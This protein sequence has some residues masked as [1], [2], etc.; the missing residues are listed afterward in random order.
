MRKT[1]E[2]STNILARFT[3]AA[4]CAMLLL[5]LG[6]TT[7]SAQL[8]GTKNIPGDYATLAA[9]ITDLNAQGVGAGG[10]TISLAAANPQTAPAGGY[11]IGDTGSF[12]LTTASAANPI[13]IQGNGNTITAPTTQVVGSLNDAIFKL[14]GADFVTISGFTMTENAA[15]TTTAA[16][17]NN[18]TEFGVALFYV[19]A[20]DGA[21][22]NSIISNT[23]DLD[24]TYQN[25][26]G[27]YSN[28]R[29]N[30][31]AISTTADITAATGANNNLTVRSNTIT[32]VNMGVVSIGS[33]TT[34]FYNVG[35]DIGGT[36]IATGN[37]ITNFGTTATFSGYVSV[38]GTVNGAY[39][40]NTVNAN[41]SYNTIN[42]SNGGVTVST[43]LR[44]VFVQNTG[45]APTTGGPFNNTVNNN[46]I[47]LRPANATA[48]ITAIEN[49]LGTAV[50]NF[51][52]NTNDFNTTGHTVAATGAVTFI[53]SSVANQNQN[54]NNNTFSNL[55]LNT[56]GATTFIVASVSLPANG[57]QNVNGNSIVTAFNK[58]GAGGMVT[59]FTNNGSSPGTVVEQNNNNNFSNITVTGAT[60]IV[61]FSNTDGGTPTKTVTGN[62]FNN[63]TGGTSAVTAL[64]V[65]FQ[66]QATVSGNTV[67]NI[68]NG[69]AITGIS[70]AS[71]GSV[72]ADVLTQN[73]VFNLTG[74]GTGTVVGISNSG[75]TT[76]NIT[77]NR[78]YNISN[79]NALPVASGIT[80]S[81]G[82]TINVQNN[83]VGNI[84]TPNSGST[85]SLFGINIS[86]GTTV[87]AD[88]NTVYLN[89]TS[90]GANFGSSALNA[91]TTPNV[92]L[93]NNNL[94]NLSTATGT[95]VTVAY[96]R[97][98]AT[99]TTYNAASNANNLY[100]GTPGIANLLY[101]DSATGDQTLAA[102]KAR[103]T[104]RDGSSVSVNPPFLSTTGSAPTFLHIDP[105]IATQLESG[106]VMVAGITV[107]FDGDTRNNPPDIGADEFAGIGIDLTGPSI[108]YTPLVN[109]ATTTNRTLNVTITDL[110]GVAGGSLSPRIYF[111]KNGGAFFSTQCTG[112]AP[113][114]VCTID[115]ALIGGVVAADIVRYFVIAQDTLNNVSANPGAGLVASDVNNV[116]TP[117]TTP[118]QYTIV[119]AFPASVSVGTAGADY[120]S[121]TNAGGLFAALNAGTLNSNVTVNIITD[122]TGELGTIQLGQLAEDAPGGFIVTIKPTGAARIITGSSAAGLITLNGA[123]R[124]VIDGSTSGGTDR[125]LTINNTN[126]GTSAGVIL[127]SSGAS[128]AQS[129]TVRNVN[130]IGNAAATLTTLSGIHVG[131]AT[132]GSLATVPNTNIVLNNNSIQSTIFGISSLGV[133]AAAKDTGT[134]ITGN[135]MTGTGNN[136][137]GRVGMYI[138]YNN[139][140][141]IS[142][143]TISGIVSAENADAVGIAVGQQG[144]LTI[145]A[146]GAEVSNAT[147]SQNNI[148]IVQQTNTFSA[149]GIILG[150]STTGTNNVV[151][152]TV[153]GVIGNSNSGDIVTGIYVGTAAGGT[154][155]VNFNSVSMTGDRGATTTQ[156]GSFALSIAGADAPVNVRNNIL[157]NTQTQSGGGA[158]GRSYA[159]GIGY[160]TFANLNSDYN[161]LYV[162]GAQATLGI[163]GALLNVA[164][165]GTGIDYSTLALFRGATGKD[166]N[167]F[168]ADPL[169]TST[170]DLHLQQ[171][172][173][174]VGEGTPIAGIT[175]DLDGN[176]RDLTHPDIGADEITPKVAG[177]ALAS[178]TL[179]GV[180]YNSNLTVTGTLTLSGIVN[181]SGNTLIL[182]CGTNVVGAGAGNYVV[183]E[184]R[185]EFCANGESFNYPVGANGYSPVTAT[186]VVI[187]TNPSSLTVNAVN[188]PFPGSRLSSV[189]GLQRYW[190]LQNGGLTSA[191]LTFE[192]PQADVLGDETMYRIV[193]DRIGAA[194]T[195]FPD[196]LADNVDETTNIATLLTPTTQFSK[197]GIVAPLPTAASLLVEGR[198]TTAEGRGI[199]NVLVTLN[200]ANGST[201]TVMSGALGY[202]R[203]PEVS[204]GQT[205]I[206]TIHSKRFTF[207]APSRAFVVSEETAFNEFTAN[208]E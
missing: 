112:T 200:E 163:T 19:T 179:G 182:P 1:T 133:S 160:S 187:S 86:G 57:T 89:A 24:R 117:P 76:R 44:A 18:M 53:S 13:T 191:G 193:K 25:T 92:T 196:G 99:L 148:G 138:I 171:G 20:T 28:V 74:S 146:A 128:G 156:Y 2:I 7:V 75:G 174:I 164:G 188:A 184:I 134:V 41:I 105:T 49:G 201:R 61:G 50:I 69:A 167:S 139:G 152:N 168:Q 161:D 177:G 87:T 88:F 111:S 70:M 121:L 90:V 32:D 162:S 77:R 66:G 143:N 64:V 56:T 116:T 51:S 194:T 125:S 153:S 108:S 97:S 29:H 189:N 198:V 37:I 14:I 185:R 140:L 159:L 157:Y 43:T 80:V 197:W 141:L 120:T 42:S 183:G 208:N 23:I 10:V 186:N 46:S 26:F 30:A 126:T 27:I 45:T 39:C 96:R 100:A 195:V 109:T 16:A 192:Y 4:V 119:A 151:N 150:S 202:Y 147:I 199:K 131:G 106:G 154:Q 3:S 122:L 82:T 206:L 91:S 67:S 137:V 203:F 180:T 172:S 123:D 48:T 145:F 85:N 127:I 107:D 113:N 170:T 84:T 63:W 17:T 204:A 94:V 114:Y 78:V 79:T 35:L 178:P 101:F 68:T 54:F 118:N 59:L 15:N 73:T 40:N 173:A 190:D 144:I 102:Y 98:T 55:T 52:A 72:A 9:A 65:S 38:S 95:G 31:T 136:R 5:I 142:R 155:N 36:S 169:F 33:M 8:T 22:N 110:S 165:T 11:V 21:Q 12:V 93:R 58:T 129:D 81:S 175:V 60:T 62:T 135:T 115:N 104:P 130:I 205:V 124:I 207:K 47:S 6:A 132:V 158:G 71:G 181:M 166:I 103:V 176:T 34:A 149:V 83:L